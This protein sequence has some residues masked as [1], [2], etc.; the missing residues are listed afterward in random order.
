M[1]AAMHWAGVVLP[2][3]SVLLVQAKDLWG[4]RSS[5]PLLP[6]PTSLPLSPD[7]GWLGSGEQ[8]TGATNSNERRSAGLGG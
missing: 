7:E 1:R 4:G 6:W 5:V 2:F 8:R 3:L